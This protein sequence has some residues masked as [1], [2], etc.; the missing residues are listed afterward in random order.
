MNKLRN[1]FGFQLYLCLAFAIG[2]SCGRTPLAEYPAGKSRASAIAIS[3]DK[4]LISYTDEENIIVLNRDDRRMTRKYP[5][6]KRVWQLLFPKGGKYLI[7]RLSGGADLLNLESGKFRSYSRI[8][9]NDNGTNLLLLAPPT[10]IGDQ[11]S[12][13][14]TR[15]N[16]STGSEELIKSGK[17]SIRDIDASQDGTAMSYVLHSGGQLNYN[18]ELLNVNT[19]TTRTLKVI[20]ALS[21]KNSLPYIVTRF[22]GKETLVIGDLHKQ[23][24]TY[25]ARTRKKTGKIETISA[26]QLAPQ[27][28]HRHWAVFRTSLNQVLII[29]K[30][31]IVKTQVDTGV[32]EKTRA[33]EGYVRAIVRSRLN[34][35][36]LFWQEPT[37][38]NTVLTVMSDSDKRLDRIRVD[39]P[40]NRVSISDD[41]SIVVAAVRATDDSQKIMVW[42]VRR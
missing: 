25:N 34:G 6:R 23:V 10:G 41:G 2:I 8:F 33:P 4:K 15:L 9:I 11:G 28:F 36:M 38:E 13:K 1:A 30:G 3:P 16:I 17:G 20:R 39:R 19:G 32:S 22:F 35:R 40:L 24:E 42:K 26:D 31:S 18:V 12:Y 7:V 14:I 37:D 21:H 27:A 29:D 5:F